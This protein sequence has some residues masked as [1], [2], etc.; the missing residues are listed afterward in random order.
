M[1]DPAVQLCSH[2]PYGCNPAA[3]SFADWAAGILLAKDEGRYFYEVAY[4]VM[5]QRLSAERA[6]RRAGKRWWEFWK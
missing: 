1:P 2:D 6:A 3:T 4:A 5:D